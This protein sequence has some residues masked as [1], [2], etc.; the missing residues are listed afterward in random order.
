MKFGG[1]LNN[2]TGSLL[3]V[4]CKALRIESWLSGRVSELPE[5]VYSY[6]SPTWLTQTWESCRP[7][8][9]QVIGETMELSPPREKEDVELMWLFIR[10]RYQHME[11]CMLNRCRLYLRVIYLS[12]ICNA[13]RTKLEQYLW[14]LPTIIESPYQ[15]PLA[16]NRT[17]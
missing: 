4:S 3:Q 10:T 2:L 5:C 8:L 12:D 13:G 6:I 15:W 16:F 11:L 9:V 7:A 17:D 14:N 1:K